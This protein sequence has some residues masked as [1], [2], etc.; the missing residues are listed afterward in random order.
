MN[1]KSYQ[2]L[3]LLLL[4]AGWQQAK[5]WTQNEFMIGAYKEPRLSHAY[6]SNPGNGG[7]VTTDTI[8]TSRNVQAD[9]ARWQDFRNGYFN[10]A[11]SDPNADQ[12]SLGWAQCPIWQTELYSLF[13]ASKVGVKLIVADLN[14]FNNQTWRLNPLEPAR[15]TQF[16]N[17]YIDVLNTYPNRQAALYGY[18][19]AEEPYRY[20]NNGNITSES[21]NVLRNTF[22]W[23]NYISR[24]DNGRLCF[25]N[26]SPNPTEISDV[27]AKTGNQIAGIPGQYSLM[28]PKRNNDGSYSEPGIDTCVFIEVDCFN[29]INQISRECHKKNAPYWPAILA[30]AHTTPSRILKA[31]AFN[32]LAFN[33]FTQLAYGA[34]GLLYYTYEMP[35]VAL[36]SSDIPNP[37]GYFVPNIER[38]LIGGSESY[39]RA[40]RL[41]NTNRD[42]TIYNN[43]QKINYWT[44]RVVAPIIMRSSWLGTYHQ[45]NWGTV[46]P[47]DQSYVD[48]NESKFAAIEPEYGK[49]IS[50]THLEND[51]Y[52][53]SS[54]NFLINSMSAY[55]PSMGTLGG[56]FLMSGVFEDAQFYYLLVVNKNIH[57]TLSNVKIQLKNYCS[58]TNC[59][60]N[61]YSL[62]QVAERC[63]DYINRVDFLPPQSAIADNST[64]S[65]SPATVTSPSSGFSDVHLGTLNGGEMRI[66]KIRRQNTK[67]LT[68]LPTTLYSTNT[69]VVNS[70]VTLASGSTQTIP[71]GTRIVFE[72]GGKI[73]L[74]GK[75]LAQGTSANKIVFDYS[76]TSTPTWDGKG[77]D[78]I[79]FT[80]TAANGSIMENIDNRKGGYINFN[81]EYNSGATEINIK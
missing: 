50:K 75:I 4:L 20:D 17:R 14:C 1:S 27:L 19:L 13:I 68:R 80:G 42:P 18:K 58:C 43:V 15:I 10:L 77:W 41:T 22:D 32:E 76:Q 46:V 35:R 7:E 28:V 23:S 39:Y 40:I 54:Q 63:N 2:V 38:P 69:Y 79:V 78:G 62:I 65:V 6:C 9:I 26:T 30:G 24:T 45:N 67:S 49:N 3:W 57:E 55:S 5:A 66:V 25:I 8:I 70:N 64:F 36:Q 72:N 48:S 60:N 31:T 29:Y 74:N 34:K 81:G 16:Q 37:L 53:S 71:A 12:I 73:T 44:T 59:L 52:I 47:Y 11:I 33:V 51:S 21:E 61:G 56:N